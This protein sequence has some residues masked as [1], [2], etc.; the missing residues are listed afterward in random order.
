MGTIIGTK[1]ILYFTS[2][3]QHRYSINTLD[4][5]NISLSS[6]LN[7]ANIRS[8]LTLWQA[9]IAATKQRGLR[10]VIGYVMFMIVFL[11]N[12]PQ[13]DYFYPT[14]EKQEAQRST[15]R[16]GSAILLGQPYGS[17]TT[18][19]KPPPWVSMNF[20]SMKVWGTNTTLSVPSTSAPP[21]I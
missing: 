6:V 17:L 1:C 9:D 14:S 2:I 8:N 18:P 3:S 21:N 5:G 20:S 11:M 4:T 12:T 16:Q 7:K 13:F 15:A 10:Y 19:C